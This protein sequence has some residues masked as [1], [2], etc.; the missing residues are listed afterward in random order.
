[1]A[2]GKASGKIILLG[3][4]FVIPRIAPEARHDIGTGGVT[5]PALAFPLNEIWCEVKVAPSDHGRYSAKVPGN[6]DAEYIE[7][8]MSRAVYAAIQ[9]LRMDPA[10]QAFT[11]E[12]TSNFPV[13]RGLGSSASFAVALARAIDQYRQIIINEKAD[14]DELVKATTAVER[15]FHGTPSGLDAA[16]ILSGRPIRFESGKV[17]REVANNAVD[18]VVVDAGNRDNC[19]TLIKQVGEFRERNGAQ[20]AGMAEAVVRLVDQCEK[21]LGAGDAATVAKSVREKHAILSELGLSNATIDSII[22]DATAQGALAGKVSGAGGGGAVLLIAK[23]GDGKRLAQA[24]RDL[25]WPV[26]ATD[27]GGPNG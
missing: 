12:S 6:E 16:T 9:A 13:S 24:M 8:L 10:S 25:R 14:W 18:F 3:E 23:K 22:S 26:L 17:V 2:K 27:S 4:H 20:W 21:A 19:G 7:N 11:V 1:M 5:V 15:I